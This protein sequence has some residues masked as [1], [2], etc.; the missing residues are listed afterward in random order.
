MLHRSYA[1]SMATKRQQ[2]PASGKTVFVSEGKFVAIQARGNVALP[3][4]VRRRAGLDEPGAQVEVRERADGVIELIPQRAIP[5]AQSWFWTERWQA[6]ERE[7][8][9][10]VA[11]GREATHDSGDAF[12]AHLD[13]LESDS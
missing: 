6:K 11:A 2:V 3:A 13:Q 8:D 1:A 4:D 5:A 12:L 9:E 7:V 10:H